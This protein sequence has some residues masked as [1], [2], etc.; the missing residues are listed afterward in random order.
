MPPKWV[1]SLKIQALYFCYIIAWMLPSVQQAVLRH[2]LSNIRD[3][4]IQFLQ[5]Q[6]RWWIIFHTFRVDNINIT[7]IIVVIIMIMYWLFSYLI[8]LSFIIY[9]VSLCLTQLFLWKIRTRCRLGNACST[10][11][12]W[13]T[14]RC[15]IIFF[16]WG[17][18]LANVQEL[19]FSTTTPFKFTQVDK[20]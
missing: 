16:I 15:L 13:E 20:I 4:E 6:S 3:M 11:T 12:I 17:S 10:A 8:T 9:K 5:Y 14:S 2:N 7:I 1:N 19:K 18:I